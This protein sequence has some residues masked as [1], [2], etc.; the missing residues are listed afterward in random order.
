[1]K[2]TPNHMLMTIRTLL[3]EPDTRPV[4]FLPLL[5]PYRKLSPPADPALGD[6]FRRICRMAPKW[7]EY[8]FPHPTPSRGYEQQLGITHMNK[9]LRHSLLGSTHY[10]LDCTLCHF[11][12]LLHFL[13]E[14]TDIAGLDRPSGPR[15]KQWIQAQL[16]ME[17]QV[18]TPEKLVS[19]SASTIIN[20]G[21]TGLIHLLRPLRVTPLH[22][23]SA[24]SVNTD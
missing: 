11:S 24:S 23:A 6:A 7:T 18:E 1:M 14:V 5:L 12:I 13:P 4:L 10:N 2:D 9:S 15:I 22:I 16:H 17:E 8:H 20:G 19:Q 3:W 21:Q